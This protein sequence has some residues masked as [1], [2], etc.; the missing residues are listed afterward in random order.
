MARRT[1]PVL[2][3]L[4]AA[5]CGRGH[6]G[7]IRAS[8]TIEATQVN[9][10]AKTG[11]QILRLRVDEGSEVKPGD[12]IA[13]ID[14]A[15]LDLQLRQA[16][17]GVAVARAALDN[18]RRDSE[19]T[20]T[21]FASGSATAKQRDDAA[22]RLAGSQ[23]SCDQAAATADLIRKQIADCSVA[24]P[25]R[26]TVTVTPFEAGETVPPGATLATIAQLE[27]VNLM[28]YVTEKELARI[29]PGQRATVTIDA[30]RDKSYGGTVVYVSPAAEFTPKNV[31]TTEDR[32]KQ[33]FG[34]KLQIDNPARELKP[35]LP[36]DA[37]LIVQ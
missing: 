7:T 16:M 11:G 21:L 10:A 32:V 1:I 24:A 9:V 22:A 26:G 29:R 19:R 5:A 30:F 20:A 34:V 15:T 17:A 27:R 13:V 18:D 4:L 8:G 6:N 14:H 3:L 25:V 31:Q 37:A 2:A 28:I 35:G 12:T 33:V 36:A 23:A